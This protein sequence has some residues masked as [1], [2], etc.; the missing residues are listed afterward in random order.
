M[1]ERDTH[2]MEQHLR[3]RLRDYEKG[4]AGLQADLKALRLENL[5]LNEEIKE[6]KAE[7]ERLHETNLDLLRELGA[8]SEP[9]EYR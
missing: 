2:I 9:D 8:K 6:L 1:T 3:D 5:A 7:Q 4:W